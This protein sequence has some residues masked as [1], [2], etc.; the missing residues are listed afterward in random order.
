MA[1]VIRGS[2]TFTVPSG[3]S[4]QTITLPV[5][6]NAGDVI[7]VATSAQGTTT[8]SMSGGSTTTWTTPGSNV[9]V[10]PTVWTMLGYNAP[11]GVTSA[12][13]TY[14]T[15]GAGSGACAVISG[16]TTTNPVVQ[17]GNASSSSSPTATASLAN[18][19]RATS[20]LF[21]ATSHFGATS[22]TGVWSV[23]INS[24]FNLRFSNNNSRPV[25]IDYKPP[26]GSVGATGNSVTV[27]YTNSNSGGLTLLELNVLAT[28]IPGSLAMMG[29][30]T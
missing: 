21:Y 26:T 18:A 6:T 15:G 12:T 30:G 1:A 25:G 16:L 17:S 28:S 29:V 24:F 9:G 19:V 13:L 23:D 27:T 7:I 3:S 2:N 14:S 11:A 8:F 4:T 5:T 10:A 22:E 20:L